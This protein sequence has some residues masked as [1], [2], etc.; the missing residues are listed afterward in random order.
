MGYQVIALPELG[1]QAF[2]V[3]GDGRELIEPIRGGSLVF[4]PGEARAASNVVRMLER[5]MG[6]TPPRVLSRAEAL[7]AKVVEA[8]DTIGSGPAS[9]ALVEQS[10]VNEKFLRFSAYDEDIRI[11]ADGS[12]TSGTY[13]TTH[14]DGMAHVETGMDAVRRYAL[15]N[16][17]PAVHR[18]YLGPPH[19]IP[20][21]RGTA[22]PAFGQPG[23]GVE[24]IVV[25]GAPP[26]TKYQQDKIPPG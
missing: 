8:K 9:G 6:A 23:G 20:V 19:P 11:Q 24:V 12:V 1:P 22:Q 13:V 2:A 4:E 16:P 3:I 18:F 21:Q 14:Q 15:P 26:R 7:A 5:P 25:S 10:T 17:A